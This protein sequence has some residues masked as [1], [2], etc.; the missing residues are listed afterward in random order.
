MLREWSEIV[1]GPKWKTFIRRLSRTRSGGTG[2]AA[3]RHGKYHYDPLSYSLNF[4][5]GP[6]STDLEAEDAE[7]GSFRN[8]SA[9]FAAVPGPAKHVTAVDISGKGKEVPVFG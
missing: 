1:A 2:G 7:Y 6:N 4:D 9:R 5:E 3:H 8:F